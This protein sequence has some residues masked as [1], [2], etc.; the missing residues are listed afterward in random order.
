M[1][2]VPRK[3]VLMKL[4]LVDK[5]L[6]IGTLA[7]LL[8][9]CRETEP[10]SATPIPSIPEIVEM[11]SRSVVHIQT[12]SVQLNQ[13]NQPVPAGGV[14]TGQVIDE[15]GHILTNNHVVEGAERIVVTLN[16]DREFEAVFIGGDFFT[17]LAVVRIDAESLVP[18][19]IGESSKLR[20]GDQV[21]AIGHALDLPGGPTV[22]GGW[23]SALERSIDVSENNTM[24]HLIQTDAAIN[25][26]NSGG[27]LVNARGQMVGINT[28]RTGSAEGI[29]FAIAIDHALPLIEELKAKGIV[30][31]SFLGVITV[32]ITGGLAMNL[33]LSVDAGAGIVSIAPG[34]PAETAGLRVSDI[35]VGLAGTGLTNVAELRSILA[36]YQSGATVDVEFYRD[37]QLLTVS[38]T[39][40]DRPR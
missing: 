25:P 22:T 2:P 18:I 29:G 24:Q 3:A 6:L 31:R 36:K 39:L 15:D 38:V 40:E 23:V 19:P 27:P 11:I 35:I 12:E 8:G 20:V 26:G 14:G 16:D 4:V 7:I 21:I 37:D 10:P 9:A 33:G 32:N 5:I 17:D 1:S 28:I 30:E 34:S 13:F